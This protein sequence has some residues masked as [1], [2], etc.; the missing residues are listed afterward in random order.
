MIA[1][2]RC[3]EGCDP[4]GLEEGRLVHGGAER[5]AGPGGGSFPQGCHRPRGPVRQC[6]PENHASAR[7]AAERFKSIS[8]IFQSCFNTEPGDGVSLK[9]LNKALINTTANSIVGTLQCNA[10][11]GMGE[12][13]KKDYLLGNIILKIPKKL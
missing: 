11:A 10:A 1:A 7:V 4:R 5:G 3:E 9:V 2:D 8:C 6:L 13:R 12:R